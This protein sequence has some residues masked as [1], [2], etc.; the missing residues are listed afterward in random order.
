[1]EPSSPVMNAPFSIIA[2]FTKYRLMGL[3]MSNCVLA[4]YL[5]MDQNAWA[6]GMSSL[7]RVIV[8]LDV[9]PSGAG[10]CVFQWGHSGEWRL[11]SQRGG[12]CGGVSTLC[13]LMVFIPCLSIQTWCSTSC[14][15]S[16]TPTWKPSH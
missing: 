16:V 15:K 12:L 4:S 10:A 3:M 9:E 2:L 7:G 14:S 6:C 13:L 8:Y 5:V 1:M 11:V